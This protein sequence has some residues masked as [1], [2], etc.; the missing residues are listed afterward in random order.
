MKAPNEK[1]PQPRVLMP[2][3]LVHEQGA[4]F[5]DL[6][7]STA[8][9]APVRTAVVHPC[10]A[11]SLQGALEAGERE[12]IVPVLV[13]PLAKIE[14]A[15]ADC[16]HELNNVE[17]IDVAHSHAAAEQAV[18][19]ARAG[20]VDMLMKGKLHTDELLKPAVNKTTGL[21]TERR[22]SHV[23]ALDV[24]HYHKLLFVS[25]AAINIF[26]D[27]PTKRDIVQNAI[28]LARALD[29]TLPK[30]A[31]LSAVET[32]TPNLPSTVDAA[33]LCKMADRGQ[34]TGGALDGPLAFDNAVSKE[35]AEAKG[36][37]SDVAGDADILILPDLEA[38]NMVAKQLIYLA[39]AEAAGLVLGARV[40]I[41]LTS[42]ADG[43]M[44]R[45]AS[46]AMAQ[47]FVHH[48]FKGLTL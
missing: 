31:V 23:F 37:R 44:S 8:T 12:M 24:P 2:K 29:V 14:A 15:A 9:L 20:K 27:L 13:G 25:D 36:I 40:P 26:P 28:E 1:I 10:D 46:A 11:V 4:R 3:A 21:R 32:V 41:V 42:R 43:V 22:M 5:N 33:A 34:I 17:I 45:L 16:N 18:A 30:V 35:A 38:G 6:I 39:Q 47:L 48:Q 19:L 7:N